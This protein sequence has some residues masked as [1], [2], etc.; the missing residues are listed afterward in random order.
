VEEHCPDQND[1]TDEKNYFVLHLLAS[2]KSSGL[3][4][5]PDEPMLITRHL[6]FTT[7]GS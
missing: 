4:Q 3:M 5:M 7:G 1:D 6:V 2:L